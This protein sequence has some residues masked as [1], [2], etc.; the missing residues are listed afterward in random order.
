VKP[1]E[2]AEEEF[3]P[4]DP[5]SMYF[6]YICKKTRE[7]VV[8]KKVKEQRLNKKELKKLLPAPGR[9]AQNLKPA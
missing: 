5:N 8:K 4:N 9:R 7:L 1:R 3:D 2:A 6:V